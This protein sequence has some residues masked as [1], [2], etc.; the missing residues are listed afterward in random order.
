MSTKS[1]LVFLVSLTSCRCTAT[2]PRT[3]S[4]WSY[5]EG[6]PQDTSDVHSFQIGVPEDSALSDVVRASRRDSHIEGDA[7][8][9]QLVVSMHSF[10]IA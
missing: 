1:V 6:R 2:S 7:G 5:S 9:L 8:V 3:A 4:V 10:G